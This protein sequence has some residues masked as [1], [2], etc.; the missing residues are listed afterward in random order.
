MSLNVAFLSNHLP[1]RRA[2]IGIGY[3]KINRIGPAE[4]QDND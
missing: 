1:L 4:Q 3:N 2:S